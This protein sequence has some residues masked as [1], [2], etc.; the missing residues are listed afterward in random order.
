MLRPGGTFTFTTKAPAASTDE[1][2][3]AEQTRQEMIQGVQLYLHSRELLDQLWVAAGLELLKELRL[4]VRT[5]RSTD[6]LFCA[7]V[8][9]R[10]DGNTWERE[11]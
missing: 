10:G 11:R 9:R 2:G 6:D 3:A 8:T 4:V 1:A 5:G 7:F